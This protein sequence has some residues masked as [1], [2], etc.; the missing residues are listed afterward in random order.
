MQS[1]K[2]MATAT[3]GFGALARACRDRDDWPDIL[4]ML[5]RTVVAAGVAG[6]PPRSGD[7]A[8]ALTRQGRAT[9]DAA[10]RRTLDDVSF[11][12]PHLADAT[13]CRRIRAAF[14]DWARAGVPLSSAVLVIGAGVDA[15]AD[16]AARTIDDVDIARRTMT[17]IV[18][19]RC[20]LLSEVSA[21]VAEASALEQSHPSRTPHE[22]FVA[23]VI[24]GDVDVRRA[25]DVGLPVA[26][27][28]QVLSLAPLDA[29]N[30]TGPAGATLARAVADALGPAAL[31]VISGA[32]GTTVIPFRS[33]EDA[34]SPDVVEAIGDAIATPLLCTLVI[35][36]AGEVPELVARAD[37]LLDLARA[38]GRGPGLYTMDDLVIEYQMTRPGPARD[39]LAALIE[40]L[41]SH[42]DLLTTLRVHMSCGMNRRETARRLAV[43]PNTVDNRMSRVAATIG[44]DMTQPRSITQ[45]RSAILAFDA[46]SAGS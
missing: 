11:L 32:G 46:V 25:A 39:G 2:A 43:H 7:T 28:Y 22:Q 42:E 1:D 15:V 26:D 20:S 40:P 41:R 33:R 30:G 16:T 13:P 8:L 27:R 21:I 9:L 38:V 31:S 34:I 44:L 17:A 37:E 3:T 10:V 19:I 35:G 18:D 6:G 36:D 12:R 23:A 24:R 29:A 45:T 14:T 4:G 5:V